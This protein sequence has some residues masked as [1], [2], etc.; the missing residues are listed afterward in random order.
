MRVSQIF[1]FCKSKGNKFDIEAGNK[2]LNQLNFIPLQD[3][4][5]SAQSQL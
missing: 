3:S 4:D 5:E 1:L 2:N